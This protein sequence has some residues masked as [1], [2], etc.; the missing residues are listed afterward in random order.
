MIILQLDPSTT[1]ATAVRIS[2]DWKNLIEAS[3]SI[4]RMLMFAPSSSSIA[5]PYAYL[6]RCGGIPL[7]AVG[8]R[9]SPALESLPHPWT[10]P[11]K[12]LWGVSVSEAPRYIT[13]T[14]GK[15]LIRFR[16][17]KASYTT[18]RGPEGSWRRMFITDP[19]CTTVIVRIEQSSIS[20]LH[21]PEATYSVRDRCG[22]RLGYLEDVVQAA[23]A[24]CHEYRQSDDIGVQ[25]EAYVDLFVRK[26]VLDISVRFLSA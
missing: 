2:R 18:A 20:P 17:K 8:F 25:K 5:Q 1:L 23:L 12:M 6:Q 22:I 13:E 15:C 3:P 14:A 9:V 16:R 19:P 21:W 4:R 7:Y 24:S 10:L 26:Y 11:D